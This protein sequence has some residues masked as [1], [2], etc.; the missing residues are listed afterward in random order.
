MQKNELY[1]LSTRK[2]L[3]THPYIPFIQSPPSR[4]NRSHKK[5]Y[6]CPSSTF[7]IINLLLRILRMSQDCVQ[8]S[9]SSKQLSNAP[10]EDIVIS[11][12]NPIIHI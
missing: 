7:P 3:S 8:D 10:H 5:S 12:P 4:K 11:I 6:Q 1:T 2:H 9:Y